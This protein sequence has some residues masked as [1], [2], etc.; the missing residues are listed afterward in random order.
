MLS[1]RRGRFF[2]VL[3]ASCLFSA[4][5]LGGAR[6]A[7]GPHHSR[8]APLGGVNIGG[9]SVGV[10]PAVVDRE[11]A[12][13][14]AAHA[15]LV[16]IEILWSTLEARGPGQID[17]KAL[18]FT[19]RVIADA[20]AAGIGVIATVRSTPCWESSA[21]AALLAHCT[22][23][24]LTQAN[25]WPPRDP[26]TYGAFVAFLTRRYG[27]RLTAIE[28]WNEPDHNNQKYLA[29]PQKPQRYAELLRA[30]YPAIK[31]ANASV[32]VLA[33]SLV[34]SNGVFLRELYAAGIKGYY[35]GLA[36]HFYTL[37]LGSLRAIHQVQVANG[38]DKALWLGEFGWSSCWPR[39]RIQEEQACV[40]P[41]VQAVNITNLFRSLSRTPFVAAIVLFQ[42]RDRVGESF[43]VVSERGARKPSFR[44]LARVLASPFG[45]VSPVSLRLGHRGRHVV[46]SGTG[47]TGDFMELEAFAGGVLRYRAL[48]VL[49]RFNRYSIALPSALGASRLSVRVYQYWAGRA[50]AVQRNI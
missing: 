26:S 33:G 41:R 1:S 25:A 28:V 46:A 37:T 36:V 49:D 18:A 19:D 14:R 40:T 2:A 31:Q 24:Q 8:L 22:A 21:P 10:K 7:G 38:D 45:S 5:L 48:F 29:G 11:I 32:R 42:L 4:L 27:A 43:G 50:K 39:H 44:A 34:G 12:L 9:L 16:R 20:A 17:A 23:G 15:R 6:A 35:D 30:A 47:P 13:A 3:V